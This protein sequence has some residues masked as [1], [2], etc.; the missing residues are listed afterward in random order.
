M[1][2]LPDGASVAP[3]TDPRECRADDDD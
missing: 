1:A 2:V 3:H